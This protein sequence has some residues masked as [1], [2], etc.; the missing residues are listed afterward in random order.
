[1]QLLVPVSEHATVLFKN[2]FIGGRSDPDG[3]R[4]RVDLAMHLIGMTAIW[5]WVVILGISSW[6]VANRMR[7]RIKADTG[8]SVAEGDLTSIETWMKVDEVEKTNHPGKDWVPESSIS[9]YQPSK[10]NL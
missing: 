4:A 6:F 3:V 2:I 10:R 5:I 1:M 7:R 9:D 8:K